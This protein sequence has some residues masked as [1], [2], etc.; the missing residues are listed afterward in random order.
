M[1]DLNLYELES[2]IDELANEVEYVD[3]QHQSI[4]LNQFLEFLLN[5]SISKRILQRIDDDFSEVGNIPELDKI[6][7][8]SKQMRLYKESINTPE[9]Q[10]AFG[11]FAIF[12][13]NKSDK[14]R[15][16][17]IY[18]N[19]AQTWY[20]GGSAY[21]EMQVIFND[22][23]FK[24]MMRLIRWYISDS[25]S[26]NSSDNFSKL[27]ISEMEDR[28][29]SINVKLTNLGYGQEIIL[30]EIQELKDLLPNLKK[31]NWS[32]ILRGKFGDL[33]FN[34]LVSVETVSIIYEMI[35]G[36]KLNILNN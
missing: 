12:R 17:N 10:G 33:I 29:N 14:G 31:K 4:K 13:A 25:Q 36:D 15:F 32:E 2:R 34:K 9:K 26:Y 30:N 16:E 1:R 6:Q 5:Q 3:I 28:L 8:R 19:L 22:M 24:P 27:E 23:F 20:G 21:R 7:D 35:T 18:F 11:Y